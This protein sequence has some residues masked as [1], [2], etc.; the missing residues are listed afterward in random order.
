M[1]M[2]KNDSGKEN[3]LGGIV[4]GREAIP[5]ESCWEEL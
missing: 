5:V 1:N 4:K 2:S 3:L